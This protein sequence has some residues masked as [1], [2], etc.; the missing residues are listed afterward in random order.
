M[1]ILL[2][3]GDETSE[4]EL[5]DD[6]LPGWQGIKVA[7]KN[8]KAMNIPTGDRV[9][10]RSDDAAITGTYEVSRALAPAAPRGWRFYLKSVGGRS[11]PTSTPSATTATAST[12]GDNTQKSYVIKVSNLK[13]SLVRQSVAEYRVPYDRMSSEMQRLLRSGAKIVSVTEYSG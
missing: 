12:G 3:R 7:V 5:L 11:A 8:G 1:G 6:V 9:E 4:V 10:L 2:V 13:G